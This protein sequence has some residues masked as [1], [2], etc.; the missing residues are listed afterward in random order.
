MNENFIANVKTSKE[1]AEG[2]R[3]SLFFSRIDYN[4]L[5]PLG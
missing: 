1:Q 3:V 5:I 4:Y 2:R